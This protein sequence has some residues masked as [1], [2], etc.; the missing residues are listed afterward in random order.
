M[1]LALQ[2]VRK[3]RSLEHNSIEMTVERGELKNFSLEIPIAVVVVE[4]SAPPMEHEQEHG[5][6]F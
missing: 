6:M 5:L 1:N 4:S 3:I 2:D